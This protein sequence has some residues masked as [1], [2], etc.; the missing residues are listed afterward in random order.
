[1]Q[2][3]ISFEMIEIRA[4]FTVLKDRILF[5]KELRKNVSDTCYKNEILI[6]SIIYWADRLVL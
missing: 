5:V 1:M 2:K 3:S 4:S 6:E